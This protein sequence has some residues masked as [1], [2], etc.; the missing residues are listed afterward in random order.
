VKR[1]RLKREREEAGKGREMISICFR[2][3]KESKL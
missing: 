1:V 2:Q 3:S